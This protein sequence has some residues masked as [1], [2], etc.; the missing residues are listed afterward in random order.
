MDELDLFKTELAELIN[1]HWGTLNP[2]SEV[3]EDDVDPLDL[4]EMG[5]TFPGA[6]VLFLEAQSLA[7]EDAP[8]LSMRITPRGQSPFTGIGLATDALASWV[9]A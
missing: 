7:N 1:K 5:D 6:W 8:R 4:A 2:S 3:F 9:G